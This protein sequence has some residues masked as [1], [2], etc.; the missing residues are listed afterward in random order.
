MST[1]ISG[2]INTKISASLI[3]SVA[4]CAYGS[5]QDY[6]FIWYTVSIHVW[7]RFKY[8][9]EP[10]ISS[11]EV[12]KIPANRESSV[13]SGTFFLPYYLHPLLPHIFMYFV[14]QN[15]YPNQVFQYGIY[16]AQVKS[17][18]YGG[19]GG[20]YR[21]LNGPQGLNVASC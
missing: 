19:G 7:L 8:R 9:G 17:T 1:Y 5:K 13:R 11:G 21:M 15:I 4:I 3:F 2:E 16:C 10:I 12:C 6:I 14:Y 18:G 20:G